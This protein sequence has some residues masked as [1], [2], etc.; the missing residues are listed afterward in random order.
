MRVLIS[1]ATEEN[2]GL[3]HL[4]FGLHRQIEG[5]MIRHHSLVN[6]YL[7]WE[8]AYQLLGLELSPADG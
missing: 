6:A 1:Q 8:E 5:V 4:H 2:L 3:C 7:A